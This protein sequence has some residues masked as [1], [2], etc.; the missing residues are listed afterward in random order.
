MEDTNLFF[1]FATV[2]SKKKKKKLKDE[3]LY[4]D[5]V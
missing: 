2:I 3:M 4:T 5:A 1:P